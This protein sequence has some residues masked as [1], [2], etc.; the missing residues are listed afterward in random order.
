MNRSITGVVPFGHMATQYMQQNGPEVVTIKLEMDNQHKF[1]IEQIDEWINSRNM[2]KFSG[3]EWYTINGR[4]EVYAATND[5]DFWS[6]EVYLKKVEIEGVQYKVLG[7]E[8]TTKYRDTD[9]LKGHFYKR[10][11]LIGLLVGFVK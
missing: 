1:N 10:G 3:G 4:G 9:P 5:K 11:E 6:T 8:S 7:I 2:H